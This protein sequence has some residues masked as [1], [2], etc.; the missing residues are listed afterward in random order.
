MLFYPHTIFFLFSLVSEKPYFS[1]EPEDSIVLVG[2][3]A[4]FQC[5]VRGMPQP[6]VN[7]YRQDTNMPAGGRAEPI[8][9]GLRIRDARLEDEGL[10][11][12]QANNELGSVRA[13]ARLSVYCKFSLFL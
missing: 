2:D 12:C 11:F 5:E 10:Y 9:G 8:D 13:A 1:Q 7:W 4:S 6:E 3:T